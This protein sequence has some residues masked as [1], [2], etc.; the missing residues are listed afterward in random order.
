[1]K[2]FKEYLIEYDRSDIELQQQHGGMQKTARQQQ[3]TVQGK[4]E[5]QQ[6]MG[7]E[8]QKGDVIENKAGRFTVIGGSMKGLMVKQAGTG[9]TFTLPHGMKFQAAGQDASGRTV[10]NQAQ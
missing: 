8:P 9:K 1:M 3:Q 5:F 7:Q 2:T 10:F 6:K 4:S